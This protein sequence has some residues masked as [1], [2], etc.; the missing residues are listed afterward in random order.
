MGEAVSVDQLER[1]LIFVAY[2]VTRH[3]ATYAPLFDRLERE[4]LE[5]RRQAGPIERARRILEAY[6]IDGGVKAIR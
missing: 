3:G 4:L 6:T 1:A 5:A 2:L